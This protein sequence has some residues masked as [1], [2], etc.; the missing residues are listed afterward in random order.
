MS[1]EPVNDDD[2]VLRWVQEGVV[3]SDAVIRTAHGTVPKRYF[4]YTASGL[5]FGP[6]EDLVRERVLPWMARR[7]YTGARSLEA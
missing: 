2:G 6:I 1:T 3:G 5:A 4:D 7:G